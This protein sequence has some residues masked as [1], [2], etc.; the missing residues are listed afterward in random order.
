MSN[1][2]EQK[3]GL[4][5]CKNSRSSDDFGNTDQKQRDWKYN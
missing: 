2:D 1:S 3:K 5:N 4:K